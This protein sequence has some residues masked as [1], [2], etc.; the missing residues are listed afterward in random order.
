MLEK[1]LK[2][3]IGIV[4]GKQA[5]ELAVLLNSKKYVNEF[6]IAKKMDVTIN[7]TRNML[8]KISDFGLVSSER[9]KD[10]K[11]GWYTY[12]WK[13]DVLKCLE[14]LKEDTLK[15]IEQFRNQIKSR[16]TK[17][18]YICERCHIE[19][20]EEN[21][22]L[23]DFTCNEC[24]DIFAVKDDAKL[25][26]ELNNNLQKFES[27]LKMIDVEIEK[28]QGKLDKVREKEIRE[29]EKEKAKKR[30]ET[31]KK[32]AASRAKKKVESKSSKKTAKKISKKPAKKVIKKVSKK[33]SKKPVKKKVVKKKLVKKFIKKQVAKK[34]SKKKKNK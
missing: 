15:R 27:K 17:K 4:V 26:K 29:A 25:I 2:E 23:H 28:E 10:K 16:E 19:L 12:F 14:F 13:L 24:G 31:R 20:S 7:Q 18:F 8:Y 3:V 32:S 11:K 1:F 21:A 30:E 6:I 22:L 5:E 33:A 34:V 9:K